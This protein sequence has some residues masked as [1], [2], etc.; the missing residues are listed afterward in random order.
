[1]SKPI[2]RRELISRLK[3]FGWAGPFPGKNHMYMEQG[4]R[5]L[6]I[7]NPHGGDL[8]WTL[9][10]RIMKQAGISQQEWDAVR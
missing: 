2:S 3:T 7:P 5:R 10:K 1:M 8:D 9:T 6:P 4:E